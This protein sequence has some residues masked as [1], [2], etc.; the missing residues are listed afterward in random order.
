MV[1]VWEGALPS[2]NDDDIFVIV[3]DLGPWDFPAHGS[4]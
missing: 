1:W 2:N 3:M 4:G